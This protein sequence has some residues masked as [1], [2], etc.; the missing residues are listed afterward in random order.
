[1]AEVFGLVAAIVGVAETGINLSLTLYTFSKTAA[2]AEKDIKDV[3]TDVSLTSSILQELGTSLEL[4]RES[5]LCSD[6]ALQTTRNVVKECQDIF[7]EIDG[8]ILK[9]LA[10]H[11]SLSG[12]MAWSTKMKWPFLQPKMELLRVNLERLRSTLVL[13]LNVLSYAG[14][15]KR[16]HADLLNTNIPIC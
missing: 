15:V 8:A 10:K 14:Q 3:A 1:M 4:D 11:G 5:K 6:S 7:V 2:S 16:R 9:A 13:M 12:K